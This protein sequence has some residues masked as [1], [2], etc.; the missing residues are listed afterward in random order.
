[1]RNENSM[2]NDRF[3]KEAAEWDSNPVTVKSSKLAF[4][5]LLEHVPELA[6]ANKA[7]GERTSVCAFPMSCY[8]VA[9]LSNDKLEHT[10]SLGLHDIV[11]KLLCLRG[12]LHLYD[13]NAVDA[14]I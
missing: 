13:P 10:T 4:G 9:P 8:D 2:A 7:K 6:E 12:D 5:S 14:H 1:M 3:D 11:L